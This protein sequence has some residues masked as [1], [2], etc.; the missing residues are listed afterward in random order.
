MLFFSFWPSFAQVTVQN[1]NWA[2]LVT[3]V[4]AGMSIVYYVVWARK[5]YRGPVVEVDVVREGSA[6]LRGDEG[7]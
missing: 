7:V 1:M 6:G 5:V 3:S 4:I 2:V